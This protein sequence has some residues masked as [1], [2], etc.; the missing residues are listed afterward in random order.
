MRNMLEHRYP[1]LTAAVLDGHEAGLTAYQIAERFGNGIQSHHVEIMRSR[2]GLKNDAAENR[3]RAAAGSRAWHKGV[4]D[5]KK[6]AN[7]D[8]ADQG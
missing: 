3:R 2:M 8:T 5:A 6:S 4:K 1:G 7:G